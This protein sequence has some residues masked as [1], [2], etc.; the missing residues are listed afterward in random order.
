R[1]L[2]HHLRRAMAQPI[3][4]DQNARATLRLDDVT[5][6]DVGGPIGAN[7]L[8]IDAARQD[9]PIQLLAF[10]APLEDLDHA[11]LAERGAA[12]IENVGKRGMDAENRVG[13]DHW[14]SAVGA[15]S[16]LSCA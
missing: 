11:P 12:D 15:D 6:L 5:S 2:R 10:N 4:A 7:D 3:A 8:P 1:E 9:A 16:R 13:R 14:A